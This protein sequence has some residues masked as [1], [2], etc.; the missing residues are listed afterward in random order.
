MFA[1]GPRPWSQAWAHAA[2]G[3]GGFYASGASAGP[4]AHF[5]TSVH[6]GAVFHRALAAVLLEVD[7][8][9]GAPARLDLVDVGAGGGELVAGV[10]AAL[11]EEVARRVSPVAVD[12]RS[13]PDGLDDRVAWRRG[14]AP[15]AIPTTV[16]GLLVA[17]EWLDDVPLDIV[18]VDDEGRARLVLVDADG[19]ESLGPRLDDV[20]GW[21]RH[22]LDADLARDWVEHW[23]PVD[24]PGE[25]AEIGHTRDLHWELAVRR[26]AAGSALAIDYGHTAGSRPRHGTLSAYADGRSA[27]PVPDGTVNLTAHVALDSLAATSPGTGDTELSSQRDAL[28]SL[29]VDPALPDPTLAGTDPVAYAAALAAASDASE[30]LD[31]V[32]LGGFAWVRVDVG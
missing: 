9:L 20:D 13:R 18:E 23:W 1:D 2:Y 31:P 22:G 11:P 3:E 15:H 10:L 28:R 12:V 17:H 24:A 14:T 30:L 7:R 32:G 16:T 4:G 8:R 6:V 21:A 25:R 29:G 19:R 26:L 5:R 27:R